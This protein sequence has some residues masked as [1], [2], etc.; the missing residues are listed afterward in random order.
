MQEQQP[1]EENRAATVRPGGPETW[2][3]AG[4]YID[5]DPQMPVSAGSSTPSDRMFRGGEDTPATT[6]AG[7]TS[8]SGTTDATATGT[9]R[10]SPGDAG[11]PL[12]RRFE[13]RPETTNPTG[14]S[15]TS[16]ADPIGEGSNTPVGNEPSD[17]RSWDA[18]QPEPGE[19]G[20]SSWMP[21]A[22]NTGQIAG[23]SSTSLGGLMA[24][25]ALGALIY[26]WWQGRRR[27]NRFERIRDMLLD[28]GMEYGSDLP[29]VVGQTVGKS[30]SPLLPFVLLPL[31]LYLR[32]RGGKAEKA[33][34]ELLEP[35]NIEDRTQRLVKQGAKQFERYG[36]R[37]IDE[38]D[39]TQEQS[40]GWTPWLI[41]VPALGGA[42]YFGRQYLGQ[43]ASAVQDYAQGF[44]GDG[45]SMGMGSK[46][47]R[48]VMTRQPDVIA[49]DAKVAEA[50]RKMRDLDVG[51]LPVCDGQRLVG[52]ITDRDISIRATAEG[53]D[54][55]TTPVRQVMSP[56]VAWVFEDEPAT[57]AASVMRQ[58]QIRRLPVLDR[59][60][61]LVGIVALGDL[62]TDLPSDTI[63]GST[64]EDISYP[65][66]PSR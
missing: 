9:S 56:E 36:R 28:V 48:D 62:A 59:N 45:Q 17:F 65:S 31:A 33:G 10:T 40:W 42:A 54:P 22:W 15:F 43:G 24:A 14:S 34:E 44:S 26:A 7:G 30:R 3:A 55:N 60:D 20:Q 38:H 37:F 58:R 61:K 52:M 1:R 25:G 23:M 63:K 35:L 66:R 49:P 46:L 57:M 18:R 32:A 19:G 50:A 29:R 39:P 27:K 6:A 47:V 41:A 13:D 51:S 11:R 64:L 21:S 5:R 12:E 53:K 8:M 4:E 16:S 2:T